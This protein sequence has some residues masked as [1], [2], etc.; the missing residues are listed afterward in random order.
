MNTEAYQGMS[1]S[2]KISK[3]VIITITYTEA[4]ALLTRVDKLMNTPGIR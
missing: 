4:Q 3:V 1:K 2:C